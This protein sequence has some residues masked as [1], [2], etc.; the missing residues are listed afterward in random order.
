MRKA[1][2]LSRLGGTAS[3]CRSG[4][5]SRTTYLA[6]ICIRREIL[7]FA[8]DEDSPIITWLRALAREIRRR[9]P[10]GRGVGVIGMY[11]TGNFAINLMLE[12]VVLAPVACQPGL[13]LTTFGAPKDALG[14]SPDTLR[15]AVTRSS[16][17]PLPAIALP[18]TRSHRSS[19]SS[20]CGASSKRDSKGMSFLATTIPSSPSASSTTRITPRIRRASASCGFLRSDSG[21][22]D[23][24]CT[25]SPAI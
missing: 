13:P 21:P 18:A 14:V 6:H 25:I 19:V 2:G 24:R 10:D 20:V 3:S 8:A 12:D 1:R 16:D 9:C 22:L 11:L 5:A 4:S 15:A 17:V 23:G 7:A